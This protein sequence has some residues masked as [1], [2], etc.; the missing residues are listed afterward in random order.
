M[1]RER[2]PAALQG[3][4]Q[5]QMP[6]SRCRTLHKVPTQ[7]RGPRRAGPQRT[8]PGRGREVGKLSVPLYRSLLELV[9]AVL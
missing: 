1:G 2:G 8:E 9:G 7:P 6:M 3:E 5:G 4:V